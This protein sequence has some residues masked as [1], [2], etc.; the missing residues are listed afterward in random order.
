MRF[1][2]IVPK[3]WDASFSL[4][5]KIKKRVMAGAKKSVGEVIQYHGCS[6]DIFFVVNCCGSCSNTSFG[7]QSFGGLAPGA[8]LW[9]FFAVPAKNKPLDGSPSTNV[10]QLDYHKRLSLKYQIL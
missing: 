2:T 6:P 7:N 1:V 4:T 5:L 9:F 8:N 10:S 3:L